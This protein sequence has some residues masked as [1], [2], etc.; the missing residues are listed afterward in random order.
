[1]EARASYV[2]PQVCLQAHEMEHIRNVFDEDTAGKR[3]SCIVSPRED[4]Q[5]FRNTE[6]HAIPCECIV[7][8]YE[9][10][11]RWGHRN[12]T[13]PGFTQ[14]FGFAIPDT[15]V[16][17]KGRPYAW[18]FISKKDGALLRKSDANLNLGFVEKKFCRDRLE[19]ETPICATWLPM[20]SQF[21]E[22]RCHAPYAE[23][24]TVNACR[25]FLAGMRQSHSGILQAFVDPHGV[26][27]FLVRT[28]QY[29]EQTSLC[30]RT[31][32]SVLNSGVKGNPF[33]R[34]ATFEG[35]PGL[36]STSSRYRSHKHPNMEEEILAAGD[37]LNGRI[38]QERVRQM[39]FLG[40][41]QHVAL[42]FKVAK[43]HQLFFIYASVVSEK[44]V[45][46]QTRPQLLM[47]DPCM[48]E[49][50]PGAA[51]LP[52]GTDLK[53]IPYKGPAPGSQ[54][55][56]AREMS[57]NASDD[58]MESANRDYQQL[59]QRGEFESERTG[60]LPPL[61]GRGESTEDS[62]DARRRI[63]SERRRMQDQANL[64]QIFPRMAYPRPFVP[65]PP[66][67]I[68]DPPR[69]EDALG[70]PTATLDTLKTQLIFPTSARSMLAPQSARSAADNTAR[71]EPGHPGLGGYGENSSGRPP[72]L[73]SDTWGSGQG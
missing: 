52:G 19:G 40:P 14:N 69:N 60:S 54:Q 25:G 62:P 1:M 39:L 55:M 63:A 51:L 65:E 42:H 68:I 44:E 30:L 47:G 9:L 73:P 35:W 56:S 34:A 57:F 17:V 67:K 70:R 20:A 71:S 37:T 41:T 50:L 46:L 26:S 11:W 31:N 29:R 12:T 24:L 58:P 18:Y 59:L 16:I 61:R 66:F 6:R 64:A 10:L 72:P 21:P 22:A 13:R 8:L 33:D 48:T 38:E 53:A 23:F 15:I 4:A 7:E 49:L 27:N 36:S 43:D 28:V 2:Q 32:R 45:I 3:F 5:M